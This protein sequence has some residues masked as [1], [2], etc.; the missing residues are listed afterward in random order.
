MKKTS[1]EFGM[2]IKT[3]NGCVRALAYSRLTPSWFHNM[4]AF[5]EEDKG[6]DRYTWRKSD[7]EY[8]G[9]GVLCCPGPFLYPTFR[10]FL[11]S[12]IVTV[13][14]PL[15]RDVLTREA[16]L[17]FLHEETSAAGVNVSVKMSA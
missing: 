11:V 15:H 2:G 3:C 1:C 10:C 5:L 12:M 4:T 8:E 13:L 9:L 16:N 14:P 6:S 7:T 17:S